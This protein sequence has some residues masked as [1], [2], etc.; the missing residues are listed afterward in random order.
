[1]SKFDRRNLLTPIVRLTCAQ[2]LADDELDR[3]TLELI[4]RMRALDENGR[5]EAVAAWSEEMLDDIV[6]FGP[7][8]ELITDYERDNED[9]MA[10]DIYVIG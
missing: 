7:L 1:M 2:L 10:E 9:E 8:E 4:G 6:G 5:R 3:V